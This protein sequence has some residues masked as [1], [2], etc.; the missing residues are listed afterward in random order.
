MPDLSSLGLDR[1]VD[2]Y[3]RDIGVVSLAAIKLGG[4]DREV[5]GAVGLFLANDLVDDQDEVAPVRFAGAV[6][7]FGAREPGRG[8]LGRGGF[9]DDG[10]PWGRSQRPAMEPRGT[11]GRPA[12]TGAAASADAQGNGAAVDFRAPVTRCGGDV[13]ALSQSGRPSSRPIGSGAR[14]EAVAGAPVGRDQAQATA[15]PKASWSPSPGTP[16]TCPSPGYRARSAA[17]GASPVGR[18]QKGGRSPLD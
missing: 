16:P 9:G 5:R 14:S 7:P 8:R 11:G 17:V 1:V 6:V 2:R 13:R 12:V 15:R 3:S 4:G 10:S 18:A